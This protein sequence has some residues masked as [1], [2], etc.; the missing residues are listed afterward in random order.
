M[1]KKHNKE[2]ARMGV[3]VRE[4]GMRERERERSIL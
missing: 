1:K 3:I 2:F 4:E